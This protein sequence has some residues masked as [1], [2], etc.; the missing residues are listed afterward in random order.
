MSFWRKTGR[1]LQKQ[2]AELPLAAQDFERPTE[3]LDH[4][5]L[6]LRRQIHLPLRVAL[7]GFLQGRWQ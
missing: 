6:D 3:L 2:R 7:G 4:R 5:L 1:Q